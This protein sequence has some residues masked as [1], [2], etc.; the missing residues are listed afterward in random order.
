MQNPKTITIYLTDGDPSGIRIAEISQWIGKAIVIPRNKLR[1]ARTRPEITQPAVY[2]LFGEGIFDNSVLPK[3]YIGEAENF[4]DRL[5]SHES[6]KEFWNAV[7]LF[8]SD[9]NDLDKADVR[10][11]ESRCIDIA[12]ALKRCILE[13]SSGTTIPNLPEYKRTSMEEYLSNLRLLLSA[14]GYPVLQEIEAKSPAVEYKDNPLL[15][16]KGK[17]ALATGRMTN[18]GFVV[19]KGSTA[20]AKPTKAAQAKNAYTSIVDSL[21]QLNHLKKI[22][23][24]LYELT[25][26]HLFRSPSGASGL[27]LGQSSNGWDAWK[28]E[29]GRTLKETENQAL[30]KLQ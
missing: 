17:G 15:Y 5:S 4:W 23:D 2:F 25:E 1:E 20:S 28:N 11:L 16:C 6:N 18:E 7:V 26:D 24:N 3:A 13:N 27:I 10:Y 30:K 8:I 14:L 9:R 12:R 29:S 21:F 22:S 19:Y